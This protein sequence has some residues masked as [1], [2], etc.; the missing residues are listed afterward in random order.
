MVKPFPENLKLSALS[1]IIAYIASLNK[2]PRFL[3]RGLSG[4]SFILCG[5]G[6]NPLPVG[7]FHVEQLPAPLLP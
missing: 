5:N 2:K 6:G 3:G 7:G 1:H 4:K